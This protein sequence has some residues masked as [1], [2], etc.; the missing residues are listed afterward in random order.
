MTSAHATEPPALAVRMLGIVKRF[1]GVVANDGVD[2]DLRVGEV[3]AVL[4]ENGA[5]KS[6][7]MNVLVGLYRPDEGRIEVDGR[8]VDFHSPR[9]AIGAGLGMVHQHFTLVPSQ[10]ITENILL[11]LDQPRFRLRLGS[12][13]DEVAE[14]AERFGLRVDP[15]AKI[16]QISVGEQQRV[17]ILKMLYRGVRVL[18][19]DEPTAVLAP[20]EVDELFRTLRS[21]TASGHSII[22]ISHKLGEVIAIADRITVMQ[23]GRVTAAGI[24]AAGAT[25]ADLARL[26]VGRAVIE[27]VE[28]TPFR[29]GDVV[30]SLRDVEAE[31]DRGLPA[32]RGISVDVRSREIL[33]IA[34][35]AGNGQSELAQVITGLRPCRGHIEIAGRET[36]NREASDVIRQGV[37]HVPEDRTGVG[38]APNLSVTDNLIMKRYRE[39]P[40]A[41]GWAID[42][43]E[44]R[45]LAEHLRDDYRIV[46]PSVDAA[47]RLLSGGNLQRLILAREIDSQPRLMVAVQPTRGLDVGA[48]EGV[49]RLLLARRDAGAATVLISEDLDEI[50]GLAD[51]IAVMYEGR[52]RGPFDTGAVDVHGLGL[53]MTGGDWEPEARVQ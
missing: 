18:I 10:T 11:G 31:N 37:A 49:H 34:G 1:P 33:G 38:S 26:M 25:K 3:H 39:P 51:R 42:Q 5:G 46:S 50:I 48:I 17:E 19:M 12:F 15:R 52:L 44:A 45:R 27:S 53:L 24:P 29:P 14:L 47:V 30:L 8:P 6:T 22:F 13:E 35:V 32:L 2:F 41:R 4:G 21:M 9:D 40:V 7:L 43:T 16:W 20:Q 23:R 28:R 36:A